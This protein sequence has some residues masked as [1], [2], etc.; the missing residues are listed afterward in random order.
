MTFIGETSLILVDKVVN[1][2]QAE[3][4]VPAA[5]PSDETLRELIVTA[6]QY[7]VKYGKELEQKI[8]DKEVSSPSYQFLS[9]GGE[10]HMYYKWMLFC[11]SKNYT[12]DTINHVGN[13]YSH[14]ISIS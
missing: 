4:S 6:V 8:R 10:H 12:N 7:I 5:P 13:S 9:P 11:L 1:Q 14:L 3:P 2:M